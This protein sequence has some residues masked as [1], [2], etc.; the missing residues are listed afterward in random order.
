MQVLSRTI[1]N[2]QLVIVRDGTYIWSGSSLMP[3]NN[4]LI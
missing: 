4:S 3:V 1:D 2:F